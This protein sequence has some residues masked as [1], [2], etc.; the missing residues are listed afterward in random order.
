MDSVVL[1]SSTI[2]TGLFLPSFAS[3]FASYTLEVIMS[4]NICVIFLLYWTFYVNIIFEQEGSEEMEA[5]IQSIT[6]AK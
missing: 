3:V 5:L 4:V 2:I 6:K 1:K